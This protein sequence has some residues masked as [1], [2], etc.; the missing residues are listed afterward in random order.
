MAN[1]ASIIEHHDANRPALIDGE[2]TISYGQLRTRVAAVRSALSA[3]GIGLDA[4]VAVIAGN[5]PDFVVA[6][7]AALGLGA[8]AIPIL[9][10]SPLPELL[11]K[12][13]LVNPRIVVLGDAGRWTLDHAADLAWP[14]LDLAAV[15]AENQATDDPTTAEIV[16]RQPDDL[17]FLLLTSGVSGDAKVAML[18]HENLAWVQEAIT[19]NPAE[20]LAPDDVSLGV[21][22]FSHIFGLN[23]VLLASLR[24]GACVVLQRRFD[25]ALSLDLIR[26]H[27]I[28]TISGAPPM[29][30][31]WAVAEAPDDSLASVRNA[32]SGAAALPIEVFNAI[33]D[34]YGVELGEGYGLTET[35]P[36]VTWSRGG[37]I[38]PTSVGRPMAGVEV[39]LVE[40]DGTPVEPGDSGEI[41]VR[42]PGVFMGYLNAT[43]ITSTVLTDDG[44][45]WTGDIGVFDDDGYLYLVDRIKDI[46]I[47]SGFNVYP[48]EVE[49]I[50]M[51]HPDVNGA[52]VVGTPHGET[53]EA[54]V[55]HVSGDVDAD[56]L[57]EFIKARLSRYK[58][59]TEYR[60]VDELPVA[61][62]GKLIR[63]ELR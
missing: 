10:S 54:V 49:S 51:E 20:G 58:C 46:V 47:V 60:F 41:V 29:W 1:L 2:Q 50:L 28:T 27:R 21:L 53:G 61:P 6:S 30:Q 4:K 40:P 18:S 11:R 5:E 36:I 62:T 3:Q 42:S 45:F 33:K 23:V 55:A 24:I 14:L 56:E 19:A 8:V 26:R 17:A 22:P 48:S 39:V 15:D 9:P 52:V 57:D 13:E 43:D 44:W 25:A 32:A 12:L 59:P 34:R 35:S 16:E 38:K 7:L 31:R 63:R 37:P